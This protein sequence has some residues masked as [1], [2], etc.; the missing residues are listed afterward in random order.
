MAEHIPDLELLQLNDNLLEDNKGNKTMSTSPS[1]R[2]T[3]TQNDHHDSADG[4][5]DTQH[6]PELQ[7]RKTRRTKDKSRNT[8]HTLR[9]LDR[10]LDKIHR[11]LAYVSWSQRRNES[12][13][14]PRP[15][16]GRKPPHTNALTY[17][18][19]P[20]AA[21]VVFRIFNPNCMQW[22]YEDQ[23]IIIKTPRRYET[24][25]LWRDS[26]GQVTPMLARA[27]A[28]AKFLYIPGL[29]VIQNKG[30]HFHFTPARKYRDL[31]V[32]DKMV[33]YN[34]IKIK[35][36]SLAITQR[37]VFPRGVYLGAL[38]ITTTLHSNSY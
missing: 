37:A 22:L 26:R 4:I 6:T 15:I 34:G 2:W 25:L 1:V 38:H 21:H 31:L 30:V 11:D 7:E 20:V 36:T 27:Q 9:N 14:R 32:K 8:R 13:R 28:F 12:Q 16:T 3:N 10:K 17:D 35:L 23:K 29:Q 19:T 24:K 33:V 18:L 5:S